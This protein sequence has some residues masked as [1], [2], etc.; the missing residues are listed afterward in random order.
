MTKAPASQSPR[1]GVRR[2]RARG[3]VLMVALVCVI[4]A[5]VVFLSVLRVA[6]MERQRLETEAWQVQAGWLAESGLERAAARLADQPGYT[7]ETWNVP[8]GLLGGQDAAVVQIRVE[9]VPGKPK[10]RLVRV[11]AD[12][13]DH[14]Q[15]R[16]RESKQAVVHL[17]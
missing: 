5:S 7:G 3:A 17:P 11:Q 14:P 2:C 10:N 9:A 15:E 12:Y 16:A 6:R 13:P 8:A 4:I 1:S